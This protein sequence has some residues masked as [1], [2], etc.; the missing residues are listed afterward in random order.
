MAVTAPEGLGPSWPTFGASTHRALQIAATRLSQPGTTIVGTD[1]LIRS[2][3]AL[4]T[5]ETLRLL[6]AAPDLEHPVS[7]S[8]RPSL[9]GDGSRP[10]SPPVAH[11][12]EVEATLREI[13]WRRMRMARHPDR[14][15]PH[16]TNGLRV[17]LHEA[18]VRAGRHAA[19]RASA[20]H[21]VMAA[22]ADPTTRAA[23]LYPESSKRTVARVH[24]C[25]ILT[26]DGEPHPELELP[27][28][29]RRGRTRRQQLARWVARRT[30]RLARY[31]PLLV[32]VESEQR[33]QAVRLGH[34][35]ITVWHVLLG[36]LDVEYRLAM[37]GQ[38][39]PD[40]LA[41][42]NTAARRLRQAGVT[43]AHVHG[44]AVRAGD[45][46]ELAAD[47]STIGRLGTHRF[48]D[49]LWSQPVAA[50]SRA[51]NESAL[52]RRH[53]A[54]GTTHLLAGL[55]AAGN[56]LDSLFDSIGADAA[57]LDQ[58]IQDDLAAIGP[59]WTA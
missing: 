3:V 25:S 34:T 58:T 35:A 26:V 54:A 17:T 20:A 18:L 41:A 37:L 5:G 31:D 24:D 43:F 7:Y 46:V 32:E 36:I 44:H 30:T 16:W 2:L 39:L 1:D 52:A 48:G 11:A 8:A 14:R 40:E 15:R 45:E 29:L 55:L 50:A 47:E 53:A 51:A 42:R 12:G 23:R 22:F 13:T 19:T 27:A 10:P 6:A 38:P 59:A 49:P 9:A 57:V 4:R 21:V 33:R 56:E 28:W